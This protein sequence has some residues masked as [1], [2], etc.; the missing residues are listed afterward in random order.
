MDNSESWKECVDR[1]LGVWTGYQL[2]L[3]TWSGGTDTDEKAKWFSEILADYVL[4]DALVINDLTDWIDE[5]LDQEFNLI[6]EDGSTNWIASAL[7]RCK[8]W[9]LDDQT[10][11]LKGF[12]AALPTESVVMR[13][14]RESQ[15]IQEEDDD[16]KPSGNVAKKLKKRTEIDEDGWITVTRG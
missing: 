3:Q 10:T 15:L 5:I 13:N 2:A 7:L 9:F 1:L 8:E 16:E 12:L 6:L 11:Q 4:H 14:T